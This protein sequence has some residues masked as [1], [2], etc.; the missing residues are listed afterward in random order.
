L[1]KVA[2]P[3]GEITED[4]RALVEEMIETMDAC[5]GIG[6][7]APQVHYSIQLFLIRRPIENRKGKV[8]MGEVKVFINPKLSSPSK[9]TWTESEACISIPTIHGHVKRP[10]QITIEYTN[11]QGERIKERVNGWEARV[12]MHEND[13]IQGILFIDHLDA[14]EKKQLEPFLTHLK[15]RIHD[16]TEL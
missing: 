6:L 12:I 9:E 2:D 15:N 10:K 7:A 4:L 16:G 14:E 3:V 1:Q 11:L 13:H 8:E 5:N